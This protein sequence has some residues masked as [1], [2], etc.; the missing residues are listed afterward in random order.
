MCIRDR[1]NKG[2][3]GLTYMGYYPDY[4]AVAFMLPQV[5]AVSD[6]FETPRGWAVVKLE[7]IKQPATPTLIEAT[8]TIKTALKDIKAEQIFQE[9]LEK[10]REG[11][12]IEI[13]EGN[14][15]KAKLK[16]TRL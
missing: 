8:Q 9:K 16:R 13:F 10:W 7:D 5:G 1:E 2:R 3:T 6:P 4:D 11:Y 14:L 15:K 12:A